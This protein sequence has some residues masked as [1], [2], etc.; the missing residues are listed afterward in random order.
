MIFYHIALL[1]DESKELG[2]VEAAI[3]F[4]IKKY[5]LYRTCRV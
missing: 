5:I 3:T 1:E 4:S 2:V